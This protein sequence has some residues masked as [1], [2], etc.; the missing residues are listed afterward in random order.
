MVY[1]FARHRVPLWK[2]GLPERPV[3][4]VI[5]R[6]LGVDP[7]YAYAISHAP[8]STPWR[9]LVWLSGVRGA[10]EH[11]FEEGNTELGMAQDA[12]RTYPGWHHPMLTTRL[13]H[14]FLWPL[15]LPLGKT[16]PS[17]HRVTAADVLGSRLT[18]A[19]VDD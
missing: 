15:K 12:V 3:W 11:C 2:E 5:K 18:L 19:D 10:I 8:A 6:T 9:T 17:P 14:C 13:A 7:G 16:S 4:R 1:A